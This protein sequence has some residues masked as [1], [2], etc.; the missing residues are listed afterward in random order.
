M[1]PRAAAAHR[2]RGAC[3]WRVLLVS[4]CVSLDRPCYACRQVG[5]RCAVPLLQACM[6]SPLPPTPARREVGTPRTH[7]RF[8]NRSDGSYGPI[9]SRRPL[10]EAHPSIYFTLR[11][12]CPAGARCGDNSSRPIFNSRLS[13]SQT[14][15]TTAAEDAPALCSHAVER[16]A[17][18]LP[19]PLHSLCQACSAC[20]STAPPSRGST[21]WETRRSLGRHEAAHCRERAASC[22]C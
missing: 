16:L 14:H 3:R 18:S 11:F 22:D 13:F 4:R 20:P 8:L 7:R 5:T 19:C 6:R 12:G 2:C 21:A 17:C 1:R 15:Y 9:P 10:G